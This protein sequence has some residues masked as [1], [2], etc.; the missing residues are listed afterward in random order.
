MRTIIVY[1][2]VL[3]KKHPGRLLRK[4]VCTAP[5][6]QFKWLKYKLYSW[7]EDFPFCCVWRLDGRSVSQIPGLH[8]IENKPEEAEPWKHS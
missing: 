6:G 3:T 2:Y 7:S 4:G 8:I 1:R 5:A